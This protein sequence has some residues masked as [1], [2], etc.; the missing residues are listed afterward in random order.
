MHVAATPP[1]QILPLAGRVAVITGASSGIGEAIARALARNGAAVAVAARRTERIDA[2]AEQITAEG[3][4]AIAVTTDVGDERQ[5]RALIDTTAE[6]FGGIDILV[7]NAGMMLLGMIADADTNDWRRMVDVN[8][9]GLLYCTHAALPLISARGGGHIVNI[10][11]IGGR[12]TG[13]GRGLY[14]LTKFGVNGF[15]ESLRQE[16]LRS[17]VHVTVIMPGFV[18]TVINANAKTSFHKDAAARAGDRIKHPLSGDDIANAVVY[19]VS[20]PPHVSISEIMLRP[21]EQEN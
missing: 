21:I 11:S 15:S 5:A 9:Y 16:A 6:R 8:L 2:L 20:Q 4:L 13:P 18:A 7:N 12:R 14:A 1:P 17:G 19:A 3:G 10:S